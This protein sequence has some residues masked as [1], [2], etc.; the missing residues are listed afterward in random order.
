[1]QEVHS[2]KA[3]VH[4]MVIQQLLSHLDLSDILLQFPNLNSLH[5]RYGARKLGMDY[6]KSLFGMQLRDTMSVAR[7]IDKAPL[8]STL[9]LPENLLNDESLH[10]ISNALLTNDTL[11]HLDLSH[12]K[13][14]DS[15]AKRLSKVVEEGGVLMHL[16]LGDNNIQLEGAQFLARALKMNSVI[17]EFS[18][19]LN[20]VGDRGG[21][22]LFENLIDHPSITTLDFAAM[23]MGVESGNALIGLLQS[24]TN[25]TNLN[26]SCN[27]F[28][29]NG[30]ELRDTL[31][32]SPN[33]VE[34]DI[35]RC[36]IDEQ[37]QAEIRQV[38]AKRY[39]TLKQ[40]RRKEYEKG[41]DEAL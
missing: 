15:G 9:M 2:G 11:T 19:H 35:R 1:M 25:I 29:L 32:Q 5:L 26:I 17:T 30:Q 21:R 7:L 16:N 41:W 14:G 6:D 8:L 22:A 18:L 27:D 13:I 23:D 39:A 12:N 28:R 40:A 20:P 34:L 36:E 33:I 10:I 4:S 38:I 31:A 24:N 37:S 3:F